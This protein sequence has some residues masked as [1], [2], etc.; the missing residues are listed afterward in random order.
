[1][2]FQ[3]VLRGLNATPSQIKRNLKTVRPAGYN[4][5]LNELLN[6]ASFK[7][8]PIIKRLVK[9]PQVS[10]H[11]IDVADCD[12]IEQ[13][14]RI[15]EVIGMTLE[16]VGF[17]TNI[18]H[19]SFNTPKYWKKIYPD[20]TV[21]VDATLLLTI[22]ELNSL[23]KNIRNELDA[24]HSST[25]C[26]SSAQIGSE[27]T[28]AINTESVLSYSPQKS[29]FESNPF[30]TKDSFALLPNESV[31]IPSVK[32]I[33][34][35]TSESQI[36]RGATREDNIPPRPA[37]SNIS[38]NVDKISEVNDVGEARN[39]LLKCIHYLKAVDEYLA[40][41]YKG[42]VTQH[43]HAMRGVEDDQENATPKLIDLEV[44]SPKEPLAF[45]RRQTGA[46]EA[47]FPPLPLPSQEPIPT[48]NNIIKEERTSQ[49]PSKVRNEDLQLC[50][51]R[52]F[53]GGQEPGDLE[54][55]KSDHVIICIKGCNNDEE[56]VQIVIRQCSECNTSSDARRHQHMQKP[57]HEN[58][59]PAY[60]STE[61]TQSTQ[62]EP[63]KP[64]GLKE[65]PPMVP[66]VSIGV[67]VEERKN[68]SK[69]E[70]K[71]TDTYGEVI[72][73]IESIVLY[74]KGSRE[75]NVVHRVEEDAPEEKFK[76]RMPLI[77]PEQDWNTTDDTKIKYFETRNLSLKTKTGEELVISLTV[78]PKDLTGGGGGRSIS[79]SNIF[80]DIDDSKDPESTSKASS[81]KPQDKIFSYHI[82]E[83]YIPLGRT[84]ICSSLNFDVS[85]QNS[86]IRE[87][88]IQ[89]R[90]SKI[91]LQLQ[92][93][94]TDNL[95]SAC[96]P[97]KCCR[98]SVL[99]EKMRKHLPY[100][101]SIRSLPLD[102]DDITVI[103]QSLQMRLQKVKN[104][105]NL[106]KEFHK[107]QKDLINPINKV[108]Y[109]FVKGCSVQEKPKETCKKLL[110]KRKLSYYINLVNDVGSNNNSSFKNFCFSVEKSINPTSHQQ[111]EVQLVKPFSF[112]TRRI[113][114]KCTNFDEKANGTMQKLP[115]KENS[116]FT[117][118]VKTSIEIRKKPS[119]GNIMNLTKR[120]KTAPSCK[121]YTVR[122]Y[123][124]PLRLSKYGHVHGE[125][126]K[127]VKVQELILQ[128]RNSSDSNATSVSASP[129]DL[130]LRIATQSL[131]TCSSSFRDKHSSTSSAF[132][133]INRTK[134]KKEEVYLS[135]S[136]SENSLSNLALCGKNNKK[137]PVLVPTSI[138]KIVTK[139]AISNQKVQSK[140]LLIL[141]KERASQL[142]PGPDTAEIPLG[143]FS[144]VF[145]ETI[146]TEMKLKN[147]SK[148]QT[149][150]TKESL[151]RMS[152][153]TEPT[154]NSMLGLS[155]KKTCYRD[156][157][158]MKLSYASKAKPSQLR[159]VATDIHMVDT[160]AP[161][162]SNLLG[163]CKIG[164]IS[165]TFK[166]IYKFKDNE[167][168]KSS[169]SE[170]VR[171]SSSRT[172]LKLKKSLKKCGRVENKVAENTCKH[173][174]IR[175]VQYFVYQV[176]A[177]NDKSEKKLSIMQKII[178][179]TKGL[180]NSP[181][182][183]IN[184]KCKNQKAID[185]LVKADREF[186]RNCGCS[187]AKCA[188]ITTAS[189][190]RLC[191]Y[192]EPNTEANKTSW[193]K[194]SSKPST[195]TFGNLSNLASS[196][197][198]SI[199][200]CFK[201][202]NSNFLKE[203]KRKRNW[204]DNNILVIKWNTKSKEIDI[205]KESSIQN[206]ACGKCKNCA[207]NGT[208]RWSLGLDKS[209]QATLKNHNIENTIHERTA[210]AKKIES[211]PD[212]SHAVKVLQSSSEQTEE[213]FT[214]IFPKDT[215][216]LKK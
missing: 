106:A 168:I 4:M 215:D 95:Q 26:H 3:K 96:R 57:L 24:F 17:Q 54:E 59:I 199:K 15:V 5:D 138:K 102:E 189:Q 7:L 166:K 213:N 14:M 126:R 197:V 84:K 144:K 155:S 139:T 151:R 55:C 118:N 201:R 149:K 207:E 110:T 182:K 90:T 68:V 52:C 129:V 174:P 121:I 10:E 183:D 32:K 152:V 119:K 180:F 142:L 206:C 11:F 195:S 70:P 56:D 81:T 178:S 25:E 171:N 22:L 162:I 128:K 169:V 82:S 120:T 35:T 98:K 45:S 140:K 108:L 130:K 192:P 145:Y 105:T 132:N 150:N 113:R 76:K 191:S 92:N 133:V 200:T 93:I 103:N 170:R 104:S 153:V 60:F 205:V 163:H 146:I 136:R 165:S 135:R 89:N 127:K 66:E 1:M 80:N 13:T 46:E 87:R 124:K 36:P 86:K 176:R 33:P 83:K 72:D 154:N 20:G 42:A 38:F 12:I 208:C 74:N 158:G 43:K 37:T 18:G 48:D 177:C 198:L 88:G 109:F 141:A 50:P 181:E 65:K 159:A 179:K 114:K 8:R 94:G 123:R 101:P 125:K 27:L 194:Q 91:M 185:G 40:I 116:P 173:S 63:L 31:L 134:R 210:D 115:H 131:G 184:K 30:P 157:F 214:K 156:E 187:I 16:T 19:I 143:S 41:P 28:S 44:S 211:L 29:A 58:T 2:R 111:P 216:S 39:I 107:N 161:K 186:C 77:E 53:V 147:L 164:Q 69:D 212:K 117:G 34:F 112:L 193:K 64:K 73:G 202:S 23:L 137:L 75:N 49:K 188:V 175:A 172:L 78:T 100:A 203:S 21:H 6:Y 62:Q 209:F 85:N 67:P 196:S 190:P 9:H 99:N 160:L 148:N 122:E 204:V 71:D 51:E 61:E 79:I 47:P 167:P 97:A